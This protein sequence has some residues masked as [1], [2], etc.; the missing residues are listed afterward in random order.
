MAR[1]DD[2]KACDDETT[3][4]Y[5][6]SYPPCSYAPPCHGSSFAPP[7]AVR[8]P[9]PSFPLLSLPSSLSR[10]PLDHP[11]HR[12]LHTHAPP[13]HDFCVFWVC[14]RPTKPHKQPHHQQTPR[15]SS[16]AS[17]CCDESRTV[18]RFNQKVFSGFCGY[19]EGYLSSHTIHTTHHEAG[20]LALQANRTG[21]EG[22]R[23]SELGDEKR[24]RSLKGE[25]ER[26]IYFFP[27]DFSLG[28]K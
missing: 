9:L 24:L 28:H 21:Q 25:E 19:S 2:G 16:S 10:Q 18:S 4:K 26:E 27:S 17:V 12:P 15:E 8:L 1:T 3:E 13:R 6:V 20:S 5:R 11:H 7:L 22:R 23:K 14:F